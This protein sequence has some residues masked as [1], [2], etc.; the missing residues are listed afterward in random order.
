MRLAVGMCVTFL[1]AVCHGQTPDTNAKLLE[2]VRGVRATL[3]RLVQLMEAMEKSQRAVL[4][5][6]QLQLYDAQLRALQSQKDQLGIQERELSGKA[7]AIGDAARAAESGVG[8][9]GAPVPEGAP[10]SAYREAVS[11]RLAATTRL[12]NETRARQQ[13][14]EREITTLRERMSHLEKAAG[15]VLEQ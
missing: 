13:S 10:S 3:N 8:P 4:A 6:Q 1:S 15:G 7:S 11:Q 12:L 9:T 5:L 2:E 14:V